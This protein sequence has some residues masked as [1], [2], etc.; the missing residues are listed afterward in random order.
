LEALKILFLL[1]SDEDSIIKIDHL[2][3]QNNEKAHMGISLHHADAV[4]HHSS[5]DSEVRQ[6]N[7]AQSAV[8]GARKSQIDN[9][10]F[11]CTF[12]IKRSTN[13]NLDPFSKFK[14][15]GFLR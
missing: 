4:T 13:L 5:A 6:C 9:D 3:L 2:H 15:V 12:R 11:G 8:C 10:Q 7:W 1:R 14:K